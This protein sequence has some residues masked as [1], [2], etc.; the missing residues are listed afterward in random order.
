MPTR[1]AVPVVLLVPVPVVA[2]T[3]KLNSLPPSSNNSVSR[4]RSFKPRWRQ[5]LVAG[6]ADLLRAV[7]LPVVLLRVLVVRHREPVVRRAWKFK[8]ATKLPVAKRS[9]TCVSTSAKSFHGRGGSR[10]WPS[11]AT[12]TF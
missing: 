7:L 5:K 4:L 1:W 12:A 6:L 3:R 2:K 10:S 9:P 8:A 11:R